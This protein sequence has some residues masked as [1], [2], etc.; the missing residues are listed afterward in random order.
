[1]TNLRHR[2]ALEASGKRIESAI[3]AL[4]KEPI[5]IAAM[6]LRE[7]LDKLGEITGAVT[8]EEIL[9]RIFSEFCIGK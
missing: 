6:E 9:G 8:T 3:L 7:A 2:N 5:E 4:G 1:M